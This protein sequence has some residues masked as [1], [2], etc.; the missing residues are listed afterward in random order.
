MPN[1]GQFRAGVLAH[2]PQNDTLLL[3]ANTDWFSLVDHTAMGQTHDVALSGVGTS[4]SYRLSL[5]YANQDGILQGTTAQRISLGLNYNQQLYGG[6]LD[7]HAYLRGSRT[8]DQFTPNGVL[9]NAAQMGPT[10]PVY[11][12]ASATGY[13]NWPSTGGN[14][15]TPPDNPVAVLNLSK[16]PGTTYPSIA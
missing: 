14:A 2:A 6:R 7:L 16:N 9:Y 1:A 4:N 12:P 5:G 11:D 8:L 10:Q 3:N 13:Y 15:L